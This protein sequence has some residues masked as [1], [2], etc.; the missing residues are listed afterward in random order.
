MGGKKSQSAAKPHAGKPGLRFSWLFGWAAALFLV[1]R[2]YILFVLEP[3]I[4]DVENTYFAY[5]I[6]AY[7]AHL[8]PYTE[9]LPVEYP[10]LAWWLM[11]AP[12]ALDGQHI[13]EPSQLDPALRAYSQVFRGLMFLCD[14]GSVALLI[15]IV[16]R[17]RPDLIGWAALTYTVTTTILCHLLYDRLDTALLLL[18]MGWAYCW[19]RSLESGKRAANWSAASYSML[20][21]GIGFKLIP[22]ICVPFLLL[23]DWRGPQRFV[24]S[25]VGLAALALTVGVPFLI[26][27]AIS[28]SGVFALLKYHGERRIQIESL[29]STLMMIGSLFGRQIYVVKSHAAF[30]LEG[31]LANLMT[32]LSNV[33]MYG[34]LAGLWLWAF[35]RRAA[36]RGAAVY[37]VACFVLIGAVIFSKVLSP[38]YFLW[39]FPLAVLLE[40]DIAPT[41]GISIWL[42]AALLA[43]TAGLTTW[44]FPYHY[45]NLPGHPGL[46]PIDSPD[47]SVLLPAPCIVLGARNLFYL[48]I[49]LWMGWV[50]CRGE[51]RVATER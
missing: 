26:Q 47:P 25:S 35:F 51:G 18:L 31:S 14:L 8:A 40:V 12:R 46:L 48:G 30:D 32:A 29:Y 10:P 13:V 6:R 24:R 7:D 38:Q 39:A 15:A 37:R 49:V 17:R 43:A 45:S 36:Y 1:S 19:L 27:Y 3:Q 33:L 20:G 42:F 23:A 4:T 21:L 5:A 34:F 11:Y 9:E 41:G 2:V 22:V 50:L 28:G 44:L 16:N